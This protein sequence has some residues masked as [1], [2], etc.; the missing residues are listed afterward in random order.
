MPSFS[1]SVSRRS[2]LLASAAVPALA[3]LAGCGPNR[4]GS[5]SQDGTA[6]PAEVRTR[7]HEK[8]APQFAFLEQNFG[9]EFAAQLR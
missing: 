1:T 8:L 4:P 7:L 6:I 2:L 3:A 5:S 9:T